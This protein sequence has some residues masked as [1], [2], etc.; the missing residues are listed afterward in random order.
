L[1]SKNNTVADQT[2]SSK[3]EPAI[4]PM[5]KEIQEKCYENL[6]DVCRGLAA[7]LEI[8]TS[9]VMTVQVSWIKY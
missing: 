5:L 7:S 8:N 3:K 6:M 1:S 2:S 4:N 9:A